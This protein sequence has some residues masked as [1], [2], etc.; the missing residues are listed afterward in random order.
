MIKRIE[1]HIEF[2]KAIDSH[3]SDV[4]FLEEVKLYIQQLQEELDGFVTQ[5]GCDCGHP[6]CSR[7]R[8]TKDAFE[9]LNKEVKR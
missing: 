8:D 5:Y 1:E 7:C 9:I 6:H 4:A 2:H 3:K